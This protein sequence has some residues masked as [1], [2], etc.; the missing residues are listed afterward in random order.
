MG[1]AKTMKYYRI[2]DCGHAGALH[3]D[4]GMCSVTNIYGKDC[5]CMAFAPIKAE[6]RAL[7][8]AGALRSELRNL[9]DTTYY[10]VEPG[11]VYDRKG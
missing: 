2:C 1:L 3:V 5:P 9:V 10:D 8:N 4:D 6:K 7:A 11:S